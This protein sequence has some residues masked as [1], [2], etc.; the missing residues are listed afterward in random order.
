[1]IEFGSREEWSTCVEFTEIKETREDRTI[2]SQIVDGIKALKF[3]TIR[4]NT[5]QK[6]NVILGM[7]TSHVVNARLR[8]TIDLNERIVITL[9]KQHDRES[10]CL[11]SFSCAFYILGQGNSS[12]LHGKASSGDQVRS[13][14]CLQSVRRRNR[15]QLSDNHL[16]KDPY[17]VHHI[18]ECTFRRR[19]CLMWR[20]E[21][22]LDDVHSLDLMQYLSG[23]RGLGRYGCFYF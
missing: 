17:R 10:K 21:T 8:G 19:H 11:R 22:K 6:I 4:C 5:R 1:M 12:V 7:E 16:S 14:I 15:L 2:I 23:G 3:L 20:Y 18:G 9:H 13:D